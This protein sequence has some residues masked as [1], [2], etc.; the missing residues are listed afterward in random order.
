MLTFDKE[1]HRYFWNGHPVPNVTRIIKPLVDYSYVDP[2]ALEK[3][4]QQGVAIHKMVELEVKRSSYE[5]PA[6]LDP[7]CR[8]WRK[9]A[10]DTGF[11]CWLSERPTFHHGMH[12]ATTPDLVGAMPKINV[13]CAVVEVKRSFAAGLAIGVQTAAQKAALESDK[14]MPRLDK[15]FGL[16]LLD[17]GEY[18]LTEFSDRDDFNVFLSCLT[19]WRWRERHQIKERA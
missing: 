4:R 9:F 19:L 14:S 3:A 1:A 5:R 7:F 13:E 6:W 16:R 18:R 15:R 12:Y 2:E 17:S 11:E 8:A 10:G